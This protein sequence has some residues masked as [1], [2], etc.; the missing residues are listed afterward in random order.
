MKNQEIFEDIK[1]IKEI[2]C[3]SLHYT[4]LSGIAA[5]IS[6]VIACLACLL[7]GWILKTWQ[8]E[9]PDVMIHLYELSCIWISVFI[10]STVVHIYFI[11]RKS[12]STGQ[13][14]WSHLAK[15]ILYVFSPSLAVGAFLTILFIYHNQVLWIPGIWMITYGLGIWSAG[16]FSVPEPRW[17]GATLMLSGFVTLFYLTPQNLSMLMFSFGFCHIIYGTRLYLRYG[18]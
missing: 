6:G 10:L 13:R 11:R 5:I 12:Q 1:Y 14:A 8:T 2:V 9:L 4:N 3:S 16:L 7:S 15:L 17:L 18:G